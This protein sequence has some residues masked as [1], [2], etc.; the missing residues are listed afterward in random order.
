MKR[1]RAIALAGVT[2]FAVVLAL[3]LEALGGLAGVQ[4]FE[5]FT[6]DYRHT[7]TH[8]SFLEGIGERESD[9]VLVLFDEYSVMELIDAL[10]QAGAR[11]IGLD[12][13]LDRLWPALPGDEEL[14][15]AIERAGN[16]ILVTP[17]S[18][19][20][21]GKVSAPAH[22]YF[23]EV[24]AGTGTAELP[25][26]FETFR[27]GTL[28]AWSGSGLAPSFALSL[29]AHARGL[30]VDSILDSALRNGRLDLPGLPPQVGDV[31]EA[32][33]TGG[34][35]GA[36]E[37]IP[38]RIRY[39]GPPSSADAE[40]QA[41]TFTAVT[42]F[43]VPLTTLLT[44]E[45]FEDK[46]V[47]MGTGFH[48]HDR[49]RTPFHGFV[50][51]AD[52]TLPDPEP[53]GWMY[54]VEVH[55]HA[56]QNMLDEEYIR[57]LHGGLKV[58]LLLLVALFTAWV[59][60]SRGAWWG[61]GSVAVAF[62]GVAAIAGW[63]WA[64]QINLFGFE[65]I[66]L[67]VRF[68]WVPVT[69]L[70]L[71]AV[72]AY[73]GAVGYV[74]IVEGRDKRYIKSAFGRYL[75]PDVV[76]EI[77]EN[78]A[79]LELGGQKRPLSLL[80]SDLAG[81][82]SMSE[83]MDAQDLVAVLN[84][85]LDD[86]TQVVLDTGGYLDKYV[87]DMIMAF[88]NAPK[89]VE[90]HADQAIRAAIEMQRRMDLLNVEWTRRNPSHEPLQVRIGVHTGEV[91]VGNVG[92]ASRLNY[93]A[94]VDAVNL[95]ARLEPAN[96]DYGTWTMVSADTLEQARGEYRIRELDRIAV[97]GRDEPTTVFE[98]IGEAGVP[99]QH[100]R[101]SAIEHYEKGMDAYRQRRWSEAKEHFDRA[102]SADPTDGPSRVYQERCA[103]FVADPPPAD[104]DFV[105]RRTKK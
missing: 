86:M 81:F 87:G 102:V 70:F 25:G 11:T 78:P 65:L 31:A 89:E 15:G 98:L 38:F 14:R 18:E 30:D 69:V 59:G 7:T 79:L 41:G 56:L 72:F 104:W 10:S 66:A 32:G 68:V 24:A 19:S 99:I 3:G 67:P 52:S 43:S 105:V 40:D 5:D 34:G 101:Q 62:L 4:Q 9:I 97:A 12:V 22:P 49:F 88:W 54:G 85:Y 100:E 95:A 55:A 44:P 35:A 16:V 27:D 13:Y 82:T 48:E 45:R 71:G 29:Y 28:A 64:G 20:D 63:S 37:I 61:A 91:V 42:S 93:S 57:P 96:K 103:E 6:L 33:S 90:D 23:A 60:F 84:E 17:L 8:E 94:I 51:P 39:I 75:S 1:Q 53:Y 73:V 2:A 80:F 58:A 50:P 46:I 83:D 77:S 76:Q 92:G 21:S 74:S 47:L 36:N 26:A